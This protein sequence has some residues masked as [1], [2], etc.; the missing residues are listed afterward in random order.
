MPHRVILV[1][2]TPLSRRD[3]DRFGIDDLSDA[4]F[5]VEVWDICNL[6]LPGARA[7]W[8]EVPGC[9][10]I[11][12]VDEW[13][14]LFALAAELTAHDAVILIAGV[15]TPLQQRYRDLLVPVLSS[16]ALVGTV[17]S[18][19]IP[20]LSGPRRISHD[21]YRRY[22]RVRE[23]VLP[24]VLV[25]RRLDFVWTGTTTAAVARPL[26]GAATAVRLIH[27]LDYDR[28]IELQPVA[29]RDEFVL[30]LDTMGPRHPDYVSLN[31]DNPWAVGCYES[32]VADVLAELDRQGFSVVV[33]AHPR[34]RPG[35]LDDLYPGI[36]VIHGRTPELLASCAF[37]V[38]LTGSTSLGMAAVL[39]TPVLFVNSACMSDFV[40]SNERRFAKA[41]RA[42]MIDVTNL[43]RRLLA[44]AVNARAY[45]RYVHEFV[46]RPDSPK[47][48]FWSVVAQ[49]LQ[50]RW[51]A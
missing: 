17:V 38:A 19:T 35:S 41:L 50:T 42:P 27:S 21:F 13:R 8:S 49:D 23:R 28:I 12:R 40:R 22:V 4:G 47:R 24:K 25:P 39:E 30:L 3:A 9:V 33:A 29:A 18:A 36:P 44:P 34:A 37:S 7:Q 51:V 48:R 2:E 6:T 46:K 10:R 11:E 20:P 45:R 15:Y 16:P 5:A 32:I 43:R 14:S 1:V 26:I 31:M